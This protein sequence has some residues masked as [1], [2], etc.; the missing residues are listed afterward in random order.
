MLGRA[1][2]RCVCG[3]WTAAICAARNERGLGSIALPEGRKWSPQE[4]KD[5]GAWKQVEENLLAS[6]FKEV[7]EDVQDFG[8][9]PLLAAKPKVVDMPSGP[10]TIEDRSK[11]YEH[12]A[13]AGG[14]DTELKPVTKW[15]ALS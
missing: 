14:E 10:V 6:E 13:W 3:V 7:L 11:Q 9:P 5:S 2:F 1:R 12:F 4:W 15:G 8:P